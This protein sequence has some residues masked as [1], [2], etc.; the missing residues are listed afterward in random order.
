V[1]QT[2]PILW[3]QGFASDWLTNLMWL[4]SEL[5]D[6]RVYRAAAIAIVF[7]IQLRGGLLL[8]NLLLSSYLLAGVLKQV[9]AIPRPPAVDGRIQELVRVT[10]SRPP[11][12]GPDAPSFWSPLDPEVLAR[13]RALPG[14]SLGFPSGHLTGATSFF[15]G[16]ALLLRHRG[17]AFLCA[18]VVPLMGLSRMYLGV[19]FLGDAVGG[20]IVGALGIGGAAALRQCSAAATFGCSWGSPLG[21]CWRSRPRRSPPAGSLARS[22]VRYFWRDEGSQPREA[23]SECARCGWRWPLGSTS[24]PPS[25]FRWS[26]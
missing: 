17:L 2:D 25:C 3:L 12:A 13:C 6:S 9:F 19:H 16:N 11:C 20:V 21:R 7:G 14:P 5:G 23:R 15:G 22:E 24:V 18:A 4:V 10:A 1:F 26:A 8:L